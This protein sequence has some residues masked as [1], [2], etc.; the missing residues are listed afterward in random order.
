M[1]TWVKAVL[2]AGAVAAL[3]CAGLVGTVASTFSA[4]SEPREG[5]IAD[6]VHAVVDGF[7]V[8]Y[9][10]EVTGGVVLI[11]AGMDP[12]ATAIKAK[13]A[14]LGDPKVLGLLLT[15]GH[16]DHVGGCRAFEGV[17]VI[18]HRDEIGL[19]QG[20]VAAK[21]WASRFNPNDGSCRVT[22]GVTDGGQVS[23]GRFLFRA[24]HL[25]GHTAGTV[26][27]VGRK[28]LFLGDAASS[29]V[30]GEVLGAK[31]VFNDDSR[32]A[33]RSLRALGEQLSKRD[34]ST[35]AFGHTAP[36]SS[37]KPLQRYGR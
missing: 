3:G 7:V 33:D 23:L 10:V 18:A 31:W 28:T 17:P 14:E 16:G 11:D 2:G 5:A 8:S 30:D 12:Q 1:K 22:Q 15:H 24:H 37:I 4:D 21:G 26:A 35:L 29:S 6:G 34:V 13:L 25:P 32:Q 36:L 27:W 20:E 9:I 19:I